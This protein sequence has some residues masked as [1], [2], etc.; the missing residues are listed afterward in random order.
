MVAWPEAGADSDEAMQRA[1]LSRVPLERAGTPEEAAEAVR[2]LAM[3]ATYITG[4]ILRLDGGRS[5]T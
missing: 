1:Y 4:Q 3:D 2:W 5:L